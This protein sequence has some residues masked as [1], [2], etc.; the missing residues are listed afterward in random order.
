[1]GLSAFGALIM[2]TLAYVAQSP[3]LLMRFPRLGGRVASKGRPLTG[4]ALGFLLL[5]LGFFLAGVPITPAESEVAAA[6]VVE[7]QTLPAAAQTPEPETAVTPPLVNEELGPVSEEQTPESGAFARPAGADTEIAPP[8]ATSVIDSQE[9][10][11]VSGTITATIPAAATATA[12][13]TAT[14]T[15]TPTTTPTPTITPSPTITPTPVTGPT[16]L[17]LTNS[18]TLWVRRT[19]GGEQLELLF[20]GDTLVLENGRANQ[21][22][23]LWQKVRTLQGNLGWVQD[24]FLDYETET[25]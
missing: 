4:Y 1:M 25:P 23:I 13:P 14:P 24:D 5:A 18:S 8:T 19:P 9:A 2:I 15:S 21:G 10:T 22:G 7:G 6:P 17:V 20:N 12:T 16:A 3:W 11:V